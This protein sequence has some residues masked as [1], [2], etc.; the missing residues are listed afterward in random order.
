MK[1]VSN[2]ANGH[3]N[4]NINR[5]KLPQKEARQTYKPDLPMTGIILFP[6]VD[7]SKANVNDVS[8]YTQKK[9]PAITIA[10]Q[11]RAEPIINIPAHVKA[12]R[13]ECCPKNEY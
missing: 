13:A 7:K 11:R 4:Q 6:I 12:P 8:P 2:A 1:N 9:L 3:K 5:Y 10:Q